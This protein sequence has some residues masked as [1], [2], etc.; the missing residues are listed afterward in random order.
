LFEQSEWKHCLSAAKSV[1][2]GPRL[3]TP[4]LKN[5]LSANKLSDFVM[6]L[7][8]LLKVC[9]QNAWMFQNWLHIFVII[10][11]NAYRLVQCVELSYFVLVKCLQLSENDSN[12]GHKALTANALTAK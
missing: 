11:C 8:H 5:V 12:K 7:F 4:A 9:S 6:W 2:V 1:N 3:Y 10:E